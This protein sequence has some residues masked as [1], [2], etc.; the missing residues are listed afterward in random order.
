M[1]HDDLQEC[2]RNQLFDS[3][4]CS[5]AVIDR[6]HE[7]V[8]N[9]RQFDT[10]FGNGRGRSCYAV[11]K[12]RERPCPHCI[13]D[14][15][16]DDGISRVNEEVGVDRNGRTA[17][18]ILHTAPIRD[19]AGQ[20]SHVIEMSTDITEI[21]RLQREYNFLFEHV[22]CYLAI[23]NRDLRIVRANQHLRR[24]FGEP[25]GQHCYHVLKHRNTPCD[26]CPATMTFADGRQHSSA[27]LGLSQSG[28]E[29]HY[30]VTTSPLPRT[31]DAKVPY[32]I[33][34]ALDVTAL[35]RLE[36]EKIEAERLAAVGQTVAGLAHG[37]KNILTGLEGGMYVVGSGMRRGEQSKIDKGWGMI[38]RNIGRISDLVKNLLA[39]SKGRTPQVELVTPD[40]LIR[41]V[42]SLYR[43]S[44]RQAGIDI[45]HEV[46]GRIAPAP[47]DPEAIRTCLDNLVSNAL[48]A[49]A[50]SQKPNCSVRVSCR[51]DDTTIVFEVADQGCGMDYDVK[52]KAFTNFF[53][54]KGAGGT[55]LG[56]LMTRK[57]T[58]EHGGRIS[59][60][61]TPGE[62]SVFRLAFPRD[63]LPDAQTASRKGA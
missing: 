8:D 58:Q 3:V 63:R 36:R 2:I 9:N 11:Y 26:E 34:I 53:S 45:Y 35:R 49:C 20:V 52:Q 7:I 59:L 31:D 15:T 14:R 43:E 4:P 39:F 1:K 24:T 30:I 38:E 54:T 13:A 5:I 48:D 37:I 57:I 46:H 17:H 21:K 47:M 22:P 55:G 44:A 42:V 50:M 27:Q 60:E 28:A 16:F 41:E 12:R 25:T 18:Y 6:A 19:S 56:L 51:E 29:T 10:L 23:L 32:V 33:E 40:S 62:G 61:S